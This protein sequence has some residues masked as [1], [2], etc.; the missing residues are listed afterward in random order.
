[1]LIGECSDYLFVYI[2]FMF[3]YIHWL[4]LSYEFTSLNRIDND[5]NC[6]LSSNLF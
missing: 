4:G 2:A 3:D 1:M 5:L 6:A